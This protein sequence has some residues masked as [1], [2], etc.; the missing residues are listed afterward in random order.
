MES[1]KV[2]PSKCTR[3]FL[4]MLSTR[5]HPNASTW[6][7]ESSTLFK[8]QMYSPLLNLDSE[9]ALKWGFWAWIWLRQKCEPAKNISH[10]RVL[11]ILFLGP[12]C[13]YFKGPMSVLVDS[14][15]VTYE[16]HLRFLRAGVTY[17]VLVEILSVWVLHLIQAFQCTL[18]MSATPDPSFPVYTRYECYTWSKISSVGP[19][20]KHRWRFSECFGGES[21]SVFGAGQVL[22]ELLEVKRCGPG[23][24]GV[25][26]AFSRAPWLA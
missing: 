10:I 8:V 15:D 5:D 3:K 23:G 19:H 7:N 14:L 17:W 24:C 20:T 25:S 4:R 13:A 6:P 21:P 26:L 11:F 9:D 16:P 18:D 22:A 12:I 2:V 1:C